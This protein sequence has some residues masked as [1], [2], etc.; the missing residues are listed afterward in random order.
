MKTE[1]LQS[2][3]NEKNEDYGKN[4]NLA[5]FLYQFGYEEPAKLKQEKEI[6][7]EIVASFEKMN[8]LLEELK[9]PAEKNIFSDWISTEQVTIKFG[10][11]KRT[12]A[13]WRKCGKLPYTRIEQMIL[14]KKQDFESLFNEKY[15]KKTIRESNT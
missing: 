11:A 2:L 1:V 15:Q 14:Y 13:N 12:L 6:Q 8:R 3:N 5:D 9:F 7:E 4:D 10:I